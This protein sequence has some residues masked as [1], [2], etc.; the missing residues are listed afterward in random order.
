MVRVY[1][2]FVMGEGSFPFSMLH[3]DQAWPATAADAEKITLACPTV[4]PRQMICLASHAHPTNA[5]WAAK[6]W[7]VHRVDA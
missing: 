3:Q 2:Y 1:R 6:K 5:L 4:A 7:P